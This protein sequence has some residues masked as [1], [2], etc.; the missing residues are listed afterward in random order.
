MTTMTMTTMTA[1]TTTPALLGETRGAFA[2]SGSTSTGP[3]GRAGWRRRPPRSN[4]ALGSTASASQRRA[5]RA[6]PEAIATHDVLADRMGVAAQSPPPAR[7]TNLVSRTNE[8]AHGCSSPRRAH[9][10]PSAMRAYPRRPRSRADLRDHDI[11]GGPG[12]RSA[13][14]PR[15]RT[16]RR[17]GARQVRGPSTAIS[18]LDE[19]RAS[20]HETPTRMKRLVGIRTSPASP[21]SARKCHA[22]RG[23]TRSRVDEDEVEMPWG[24]RG[25][26]HREAQ[27]VRREG[28]AERAVLHAARASIGS[29]GEN[30]CGDHWSRDADVKAR[31]SRPGRRACASL[32][33]PN[34][35]RR[36]SRAAA[37]DA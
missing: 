17:V 31:I 14:R 18:R 28:D 19:R 24:A 34:T 8:L 16:A 22:P 9:F 25:G 36:G 21:A 13:R 26:H 4:R 12:W 33:L 27:G 15:S 2:S 5:R 3:P 10:R 11:A 6:P 32:P 23:R 37:S 29:P 35:Y 7:S 20:G 30:G 1:M